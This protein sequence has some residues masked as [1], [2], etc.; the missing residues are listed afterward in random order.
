MGQSLLVAQSG[1]PTAVINATL[2]GIIRECQSVGVFDRVLGVKGG[3]AGLRSGDWVDL[4][5]WEEGI[6]SRLPETPGIVLRSSRTAVSDS[7][8]A[9]V[10]ALLRSR[11]VHHLLF[12][13]GNGSMLT[14]LRLGE[15]ARRQNYELLVLG[16]PKTIDNDLALTDHSPGYGSAARFVARAVQDC[17]WDLRSLPA[18]PVRIIE[19]MGRNTGWLAAAA[20]L[21][22]RRQEDGPCLVLTPERTFSKQTFLTGLTHALQKYGGVVVVASEGLRTSAG[23]LLA[24]ESGFIMR[25]DLGRP[26]PGYAAGVGHVLAKL[27]HTELGCR[28]RYDKP[29]VLQRSALAVSSTDRAEAELIGREGVRALLSG[30]AGKMLGFVREEG[31]YRVRVTSFPLESVAGVERV[32]PDS[33]F[34]GDTLNEEMVRAYAEPLI[35]EPLTDYQAP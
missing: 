20:L 30:E 31:P 14:P 11:D 15:E 35:G 23:T 6:L 22:R 21:A 8:L 29:G 4:L 18:E 7:D 1:G 24:E 10:V 16:L 33:F 12:I 13:G 27:V 19:V 26:L 28:V 25:D 17:V 3:F 34:I 5:S 9:T 2:Y 32:L